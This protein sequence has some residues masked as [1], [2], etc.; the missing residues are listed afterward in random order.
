MYV[1]ASQLTQ[2]TPEKISAILTV[3]PTQLTN[4]CRMVKV[5]QEAEVAYKVG[6]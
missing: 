1:P 4:T 6:C 3:I 2:N 5:R